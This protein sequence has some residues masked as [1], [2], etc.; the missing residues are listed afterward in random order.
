MTA[1]AV[2]EPVCGSADPLTGWL[3]DVLGQLGATVADAGEVSDATRINRI[4]RLEKLRAVTAAAQAAEC[5][6]FAQSQIH[7][8]LAHNV[9][10][11][12]IGRGIAGQIGLAWHHHHPHRT[13]LHQP[14]T[15]PT[16]TTT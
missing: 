12:A 1:V 16:L 13:H 15:R 9:H 5:V 3:D 11:E 8:Q 10:P 14:R 6:R 2:L 4:T 7:E